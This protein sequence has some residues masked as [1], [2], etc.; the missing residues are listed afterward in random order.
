MA[1][2]CT[3]CEIFDS[4]KYCDL[5]IWVRGHSMSMETPLDRS[6][7]NSY[8]YLYC[9]TAR[10]RTPTSTLNSSIVR[11]SVYWTLTRRCWLVDVVAVSTTFVISPTTP[12]RPSRSD[13]DLNAG[14]VALALSPI[15][16][17]T[18]RR[19]AR[20]ASVSRD[21]EL[22]TSERNS[23]PYPVRRSSPGAWLGVYCT[24]TTRQYTT[25]QI[26]RS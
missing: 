9:M 11:Y 10:R 3:V 19:A 1:L 16:V 15:D 5:E 26:A 13:V 21:R 14:I 20:L 17:L 12:D 18:S 25:T 4:E 23:T 6:H 24:W 2:S 8:S 22:T 7:M